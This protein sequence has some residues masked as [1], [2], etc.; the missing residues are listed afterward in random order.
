[1]ANASNCSCE[2]GHDFC[3]DHVDNIQILDAV[4]HILSVCFVVKNDK[5]I[6][7]L[8]KENSPSLI[9]QAISHLEPLSGT[10]ELIELLSY[11]GSIKSP[12]IKLQAY[13]DKMEECDDLIDYYDV[14]E[15]L[16]A[17]M[18][19]ICNM[20]AFTRDELLKVAI[21]NSNSE[22][23]KEFYAFTRKQ[24]NT[25]EELAEAIKGIKL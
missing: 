14:Y 2:N 5:V 25:R 22:T 17:S 16:P 1:M 13:F 20:E 19:P 9:Q 3:R 7:S 21:L 10:D 23:L 24:F 11:F 15:Q 4:K 18:C 8:I 12:F 6:Q